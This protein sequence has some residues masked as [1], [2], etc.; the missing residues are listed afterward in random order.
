MS[1][2]DQAYF[3][4][5]ALIDDK[6]SQIMWSWI[7]DDRP[8]SLKNYF[9]WNGAY[10]LPRSLWLGNDGTLRMRPIKELETL[11]NEEKEFSNVRVSPESEVKLNESGFE[12]MELEVI[13]EPNSSLRYGVK[14]G[15]SDGGREETVIYYDKAEKKLKFDTRKSGLGDFG[16]KIIEDSP[17]ELK[18]DEPLI[19]RIFVDRSIVEVFANDRQAIARMVNPTLG[20]SGVSLFSEGGNI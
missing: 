4:P 5:E 3:A 8:D 15:V 12:L 9:G 16:R 20:G 11:R 2:K 10:G 6:G 18:N 13:I 7:L 1:W 17:F 19:L 14:V